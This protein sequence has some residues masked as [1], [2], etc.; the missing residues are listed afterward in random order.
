MREAQGALKRDG[1]STTILRDIMDEENND[2][3]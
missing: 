2:L 3:L 1:I